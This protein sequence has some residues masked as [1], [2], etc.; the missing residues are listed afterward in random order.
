M[1]KKL[2]AIILATILVLL[3]FNGIIY[4][5]QLKDEKRG[6][7]VLSEKV[8]TEE[9]IENLSKKSDK[10]LRSKVV[11]TGL[12]T[13]KKYEAAYKNTIQA[14]NYFYENFGIKGIDGKG[15]VPYIIPNYKVDR[16]AMFSPVKFN[17]KPMILLGSQGSNKSYAYAADVVAHEYT[18]G[19]LIYKYKVVNEGEPRAVHEGLA[20]FFGSIISSNKWVISNNKDATD[21]PIRNIKNPNSITIEKGFSYKAANGKERKTYP[22]HYSERAEVIGNANDKDYKDKVAQAAY[23]NSTIVGHL[24]YSI[25]SKDFNGIGTVKTGKLA[26]RAIESLPKDKDGVRKPTIK[27]FA[28]A[29]MKEAY[30]SEKNVVKNAYNK[31][32]L[33]PVNSVKL[34][35]TSTTIVK[36]KNQKLT[37]SISPS[38]ATNKEVTWKSSNTKV[39]TVDKNGNVKAIAPGNAT[40]GVTT[41]DGLKKAYCKVTVKNPYKKRTINIKVNLPSSFKEKHYV[42]ILDENDKMLDQSTAKIGSSSYNLTYQLDTQSS[43]YSRKIRIR[44]VSGNKTYYSTLFKINSTTIDKNVTVTFAAGTPGSVTK[45][46]KQGKIVQK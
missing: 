41:K 1:I 46:L 15:L 14:Y 29:L 23:I 17:G 44:T 38:N 42:E 28:D 3:N 19:V 33:T 36:G 12:F 30:P 21:Y 26:L 43:S 22:S 5:A 2:K 18:H 11:D 39:A 25:A 16:S 31:V 34:N 13:S 8:E 35:K 32:M 45:S 40:I 7:Y 20:D 4:A 37:A 24:L 27:Q 10:Y 9:D 6:I